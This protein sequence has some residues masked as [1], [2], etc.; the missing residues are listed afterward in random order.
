M[1]LRQAGHIVRIDVLGTKN[2]LSNN[3][4][5]H[6]DYFEY[7]DG[8]N[9]PIG[10]FEA[11]F[12][13]LDRIRLSNGWGLR[14]WNSGGAVNNNWLEDGSGNLW[15][16]F[17]DTSITL[18]SYQW[19]S[20]GHAKVFLDGVY[21]T[22]LDLSS[23]D[24]M[25][26]TLTFDGL[27]AGPHVLQVTGY[28]GNGI[29][30]TITVP[31]N[32]PATALSTCGAY[33][34]Y[35]ED[36]PALRFNG[37]LPDQKPLSW[38]NAIWNHAS[39]GYYA[40]STTGGDAISLDFV[41]SHAAIGFVTRNLGGEADVFIDG[42]FVET[43][44]TYA[45]ENDVLLRTYPSLGAGAHTIS[46]VLKGTSNPF[47][48]NDSVGVDFVDVWDG[49]SLSPTGQEAES[50]AYLS[51][52][53]SVVDNVDASGGRYVEATST[54]RN[55][56]VPFEG[57]SV[58]FDFIRWSNGARNAEIFVDGQKVDDMNFWAATVT[59]ATLAYDGFDAGAHLLQVRSPFGRISLDAVSWPAI[60]SAET[61]T[62]ST[63]LIRY[64]EHDL[65]YNDSYEWR[66]RPRSWFV[67]NTNGAAPSS[68]RVTGS[69]TGGD[70][71]E[72]TF[73]GSAANIGWYTN[74]AS[75]VAEIWL[76]GISQG[77]V[78][79]ASASGTFSVTRLS[80]IT[81]THTLSVSVVSGRVDIDYID[82]WDASP[83]ARRHDRPLAGRRWHRTAR[84][85]W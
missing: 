53:W 70:S 3:T 37:E 5:V 85:L 61:P 66:Q 46:I 21:Q 22:T 34:R 43:V 65:T 33:C 74:N 51:N 14:N 15:F 38:S 69:N 18:R 19:S 77:T 60:V 67:A 84:P 10:T 36:D 78:D 83:I 27:A 73:Y 8:T 71:A 62:I 52:Q 58:Q 82:I 7:W 45:V 63:G 41:G 26:R 56:W 23:A 79:F 39:G 35:E 32:E 49:T 50:D 81:G 12:S 30:D 68:Q 25:S 42:L 16:H 72:I 48:T 9:E 76:D 20:A 13:E 59:T 64:E 6:F 54:Y 80:M 4:R 40:N 44:D 17:T 55:V 28:R 47:S 75:G 2:A 57:D 29:V 31:A 24:N 11:D 1:S